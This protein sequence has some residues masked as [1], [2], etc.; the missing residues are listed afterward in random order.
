MRLDLHDI[1]G[2]PGTRV[3]FD[4]ET[5][6]SDAAGGSVLSVA[7]PARVSGYVK[8]TAGVLEFSAAVDAVLICECARCLGEFERAVH[9]EISA[10]LSDDV[11]DAD[12][13]SEHYPLDGDFVDVD[14]II[15]TDFLLG[16][17]ERFLCREDCLGLCPNCGADLNEGPCSCKAPID[18]RLAALGQL[19]DNE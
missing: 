7:R 2:V 16:M 19:L 15:V 9:H 6:L 10:T 1:I 18:P 13:E 14:E 12:S 5:D 4:C 8:N 17:D 3:S 11:P